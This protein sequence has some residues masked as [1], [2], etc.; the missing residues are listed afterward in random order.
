MINSL[1]DKFQPWSA[2]GSVYIISDT[3]FEDKDCKIMDPFWIDIKVQIEILKKVHKTDTLIHLGDVG[4]ASYMDE[5]NCY[6]VLI[7]GNHDILSKVSSHFDEVYNGP[8]FIS[9]RILLS[10]EPIYGLEKFCLNIHGHCHD[11]TKYLYNSN[12]DR[13][14][15]INLA[16]NVCN[17]IPMNLGKEIKNGIL[18]S[19]QNYHRLTIDNATNKVN[20]K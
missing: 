6:K 16:A 18:S 2:I 12:L 13:C 14:T 3:H 4:N 9:D 15:H 5:L 7:S 1:Y 11:G 19:I 20:K 8:L 17:Y 10:H